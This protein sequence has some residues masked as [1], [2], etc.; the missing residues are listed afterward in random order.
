MAARDR[1]QRL[2]WDLEAGSGA[3]D[4]PQ[5]ETTHDGNGREADAAVHLDSS[6]TASDAA[7]SRSA[8][9]VPPQGTFARAPAAAAAQPALTRKVLQQRVL[10]LLRERK[11]IAAAHA[12]ELSQ[13]D[14][15]AAAQRARLD[16]ELAE[17]AA[18]QRD[19]EARAPLV[20]AQLAEARA[21][22]AEGLTISDHRAAELR[23]APSDRLG[24]AD[25]VRLAVHDG[26][27][28]RRG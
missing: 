9:A 22:L 14:A 15:E 3:E 26:L 24:L 21:A 18:R 7:S 1:L 27:R 4:S 16:A 28:V 25:A 19:V 2:L 13:R 6:G 8:D 11:E 17:L 23:A 12:C 20:S 5:R 10:A